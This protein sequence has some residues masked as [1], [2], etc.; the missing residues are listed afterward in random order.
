MTTTPALLLAVS[1]FIAATA[2]PPQK[3]ITKMGE[4]ITATSTIQ[5]ID[6]TGRMMTLRNEDGTEDTFWVPPEVKRFS[7]L[8]VGDKVNL[9]YYESYVFQ[10]RKPGD[11]APAVVDQATKMTRGTGASPATTISKQ[12]TA[13]VEVL[14]VNPS[15]PSITVKTAEGHT[16]TR[17]IDN[18]KNLEGIKPGD[19]IDITYTQA[20]V[21]S[22]EP[23][24]P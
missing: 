6:Q 9:R 21:V 4:T 16:V 15:V 23:V 13:T 3:P 7:E 20:A 12:M 19:K 2:L 5:A 14:A 24:K 10:V 8:K 17:K 22:V 11:K 18:A 1:T